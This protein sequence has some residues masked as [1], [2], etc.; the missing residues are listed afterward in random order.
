M[1]MS[2]FI[3][4]H[5]H[6]HYSFLE[7]LPKVEELV[8]EAHKQGM[9]AVALT[10]SGNMHGA[11]EFYKYAVKKGVKP[12][13]GVDMYVAAH[14][15]FDKGP[16]DTKRSRIVLLAES[17]EG[18][19]NLLAMVTKAHLE[20]FYEKPRVDKALMR[21]YAK[22]VIAIIPSF[23]G[24]I[25]NMLANGD[26][27][28]AAAALAEYISIFGKDNVFLEITH[29]PTVPGHSAKMEKVIALSKE[30]GV[31][32]LAQQ[33]VYYLKPDDREPTEVMR[34]IQH[35]RA[36]SGGSRSNEQED[37]SFFSEKEALK[38]FKENPEAV[39]NSRKI[40]DRCNLEFD[41]GKWVFPSVPISEGY[42]S[43]DDELR[44]KAFAG[45]TMRG[46]EENDE[47][48]TRINYELEIIISKGFAVYYLVV[49]DL[50]RYAKSAGILT[51][52]RGSAAGSLVGYLTGIT[53]VNPLF[54]KLPFERFL[55]PERPKA[56][57]IDMDMADNRRDDM[58][59]YTRQKYG[60]DHVAQI[61]TFGTLAARAAVRDV[62]RAL[63]H[64]YS[65]GDR[66]AKLIPIGAQGF[67]MTIDRAMA[68]TPDLKQLYDEDDDVREVLDLAKRIE[69]CVRHVGV[70][71]AGV[72]V[73]PTPLVEWTPLQFDPKGEGKIITQYD[74]YS[75]SDEYGGVGLLKFDFLGIKN[76]AILADAVRRVK[77]SQDIDVDIEN[78]PIDDKKTFEML[79]RGETEGTFQLN[80]AGMTRYLK[81]LRPTTIHDINAM[82]ALYRPGPM[83]TIPQYIERKRNAQ[84]ITF[85]DPRMEEYLDASYGLLVYQDDVLLTSIKLGG[86]SWLE[87]DSLRKAMGKKIP[88]VMQAEKE[89]LLKGFREF[90]KISDK[91]GEMIWKLIEPFA[92]YGFN[93]A[94]AASYGKVAYQTAFMKAN[95]PVEY[96][97][98][99]LTADEGD[100]E[101]ISTFVAEC[102]RM[103]I[104][105]LP[106]DINES[107]SDFTV[108]GDG[109]VIRFG[110][111]TIKNFGEGISQSIIE[112]RKKSGP[113]TSLSDFLC[114]LT[115]KSLNR[116]SLESLIKCG[117]L[118]NFENTGGRANL[119]ANIELLLS[120]HRDATAAHPQDSLFGAMGI[121]LAPKLVLPITHPETSPTEKLMWEK[122][123]LGI[124]ISGHPLDAHEALLA[125]SQMTLST[126]NADPKGGMPIIMPVLI[127]EVKLVVTKKGDRMAFVKFEDRTD[128][129]EAVLFP[130]VLKEFASMVAPG[131]CILIKGAVST[132]N[133]ETSLTIEKMKT[134]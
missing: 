26:K 81:E 22:D 68:E 25:P 109:S 77:E 71:A 65:V 92:A 54:Y 45:I 8:D 76:L 18:Y 36:G 126:I 46:L 74:M 43:H 19:K 95:Y 118:D 133:G 83:E 49:A 100:T 27:N 131:T 67:P 93:K 61:G 69:G 58:V 44:K 50:L 112:E 79:A 29:H 97:A 47:V 129:I 105:V 122:E 84:M 57:D 5:A 17:N 64:S 53:N 16:N 10:D 85:L 115:E 3:H 55:N 102:E 96:M 128:T 120:F 134:L 101:S 14:S 62:S 127:S 1:G 72:V 30:L 56:P 52:T 114:R 42:E 107:G 12:I 41:L 9:E 51:T 86:Y 98:A 111:T 63:G 59:A 60:A 90:G 33:D 121:S 103:K 28:G 20:G 70:H 106:P 6:S 78:V 48:V 110:L 99:L 124:Y 23:A 108:A 125:K 66:I 80:G 35:G 104:P 39:D 32:L 130:K 116:K 91:K 113:F 15:R 31:P 73:S 11:I 89:K 34:R 40:A 88:A 2:R 82:V 123:L 132:R 75:I 4:L 117:A 87:A 94:H 24:D 21:E 38:I 13:L 119:L 7:A 37:F